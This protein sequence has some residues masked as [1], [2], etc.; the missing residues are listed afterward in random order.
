VSS[1]EDSLKKKKKKTIRKNSKVESFDTKKEATVLHNQE[2]TSWLNKRSQSKVNVF[3]KFTKPEMLVAGNWFLQQ[4]KLYMAGSARVRKMVVDEFVQNGFFTNGVECNRLLA[5]IELKSNGY[6]NH[7]DFDKFL[8]QLA[9]NN[10]FNVEAQF[11]VIQE[12]VHTL[13]GV[14]LAKQLERAKKFDRATEKLKS[15]AAI[16]SPLRRKKVDSSSPSK[17]APEY[18]E[19]VVSAVKGG[20]LMYYAKPRNKH[21]HHLLQYVSHSNNYDDSPRFSSACVTV[22]SEKQLD[23]CLDNTKRK[24]SM[25][26]NDDGDTLLDID[27]MGEDALWKKLG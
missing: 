20:G 5:R 6:L 15:L 26:L 16:A 27:D 21:P 10:S 12:F 14:R 9:K 22:T 3:N 1:F 25:D 8:H 11:K 2:M 23:V 4:M 24:G 19:T 17:Q 13:G 18:N 7:D